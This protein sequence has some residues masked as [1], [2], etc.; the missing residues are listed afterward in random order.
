MNTL[1]SKLLVGLTLSA[2]LVGSNGCM[3]QSAIQYGKGTP[4]GAWMNYVTGW[5]NQIADTKPKPLY[6]FLIPVTFPADVVTSPVQII[7][8]PFVYAADMSP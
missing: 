1:N 2:L 5:P 8:F 3:T 4:S 6:Y 7:G